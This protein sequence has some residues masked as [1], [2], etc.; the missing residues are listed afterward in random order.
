MRQSVTTL[1]STLI[2]APLIVT[3]AIYFAATNDPG[4]EWGIWPY[5]VPVLSVA[6]I[7]AA[8]LV[9][10]TVPPIPAGTEPDRARALAVER[11]RTGMILRFALVEAPFVVTVALAFAF[12]TPEPVLLVGLS[13]AL[14]CLGLAFHCY[15]WSRPVGRTADALEA[16]GAKTTLRADLSGI[17]M[18]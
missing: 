13:A 6:G 15:P 9:G 17:T 7:V 12:P 2:G 14:T 18:R 11:F 5:V 1:A 10:Y 16:D 3:V 4:A 8:E